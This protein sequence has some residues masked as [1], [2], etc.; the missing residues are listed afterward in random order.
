[1]IEGITHRTQEV[2]PSPPQ[3]GF[4]FQVLGSH[5]H[6]VNFPRRVAVVVVNVYT[7]MAKKRLVDEDPDLGRKFEEDTLQ[8]GIQRSIGNRGLRWWDWELCTVVE[9]CGNLAGGRLD[10]HGAREGTRWW[11]HGG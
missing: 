4:T 7:S 9:G 3:L 5:F 11:S 8:L 1:M 2:K 6:D 10:S